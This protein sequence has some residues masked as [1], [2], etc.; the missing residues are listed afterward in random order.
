MKNLLKDVE[1]NNLVLL[2]IVISSTVLMISWFKEADA[3]A[4]HEAGGLVLFLHL[5]G[6]LVLALVATICV[7]MRPRE[8]WLKSTIERMWE[9]LGIV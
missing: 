2:V 7:S 3:Y 4:F 5:I 6:F 9:M 1:V 8:D